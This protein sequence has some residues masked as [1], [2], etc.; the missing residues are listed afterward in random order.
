[1]TMPVS[2]NI[3]GTMGGAPLQANINLNVPN[4]PVTAP[5]YPPAVPTLCF[6]C[7]RKTDGY[8]SIAITVYKGTYLCRVCVQSL[9]DE[10]LISEFPPTL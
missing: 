10:F 4:A 3:N 5:V 9:P 7:A 8:P 2:G 1:M 6:L